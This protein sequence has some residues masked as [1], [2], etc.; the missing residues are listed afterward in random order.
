MGF[1]V[2]S[3]PSGSPVNS[4]KILN[5]APPPTINRFH[6]AGCII[7]PFSEFRISRVVDLGT[8]A[9][10]LVRTLMRKRLEQGSQ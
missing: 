9:H 5:N 10:A 7:F 3:P 1:S 6:S 4:Q 2:P 8:S